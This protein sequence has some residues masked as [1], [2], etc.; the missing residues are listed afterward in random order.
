VGG[1]GRRSSVRW[2]LESWSAIRD[3]IQ[4]RLLVRALPSLLPFRPSSFPSAG[5]A[6]DGVT[7]V[8]ALD[9]D[10]GDDVGQG[11]EEDTI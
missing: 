8:V 9:K 5:P 10:P 4:S 3:T 7:H 11:M 2:G 6:R 1:K